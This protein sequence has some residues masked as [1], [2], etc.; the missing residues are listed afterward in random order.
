VPLVYQPPP[1]GGALRQGEI[2]ANL[3]I[4]TVL[5]TTEAM[6]PL[7]ISSRHHPLVI[8]LTADCDLEQDFNARFGDTGADESDPHLVPYVQM[9]DLY[10]Q[11]TIRPTFSGSD[12]WK[13]ARQN[14]DERYHHLEVPEGP[15]PWTEELSDLFLDFK[16]ALGVPTGSV[17][18]GLTAGAIR[19][20]AVVPPIYLHDIL[21][22]FYGFLSRVGLPD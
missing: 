16:K 15:P 19:R 6:G 2:L 20:A 9:C 7:E 11:Q 22:R 14:Q 10:A 5:I 17:Y 4:H 21:H 13:R 8:V 18:Q 1:E 12:L 3:W